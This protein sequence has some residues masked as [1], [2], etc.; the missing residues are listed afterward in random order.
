M[1]SAPHVQPSTSTSQASAA[2]TG[3]FPDRSRTE[4][5]GSVAES[6]S[7]QTSHTAQTQQTAQTKEEVSFQFDRHVQEIRRRRTVQKRAPPPDR[8][9]FTKIEAESGKR[10]LDVRMYWQAYLTYFIESL[11]RDDKVTKIEP[12]QWSK[13]KALLSRLYDTSSPVQSLAFYVE[14]VM[15]WKHPPQT[16][17]WFT[18]YFTLWFYNLWLPAFLSLFVIK[19]LNNRFGFLGNFKE[20]LD[21]PGSITD[22][23]RE[24]E[25]E[26]DKE[27]GRKGKMQSQ[28]REL[29]HS[30]DLA[31]WISQMTKIWGPYG[32]ALLEEN[33]CY[34]ERVKNLFRWERPEQTWRVVALLASCIF[35]SSCF[36]HMVVPAVGLFLGAEFFVLL[37]LQKYYPRFRHVFTP[38]E[39][40]LWGVPNSAELA[41]EMLTRQDEEQR[42]SSEEAAG[43]S[44][45]SPLLEEE[46]TRDS[47]SQVSGLSPASK[48]KYEYQK[49]VR[50]RSSSSGSVLSD[51][52]SNDGAQDKSEYHCLFKGK[53]GKLVITE[54]A[55]QFR[56][57]KI[58]GREV[59]A[60]IPWTKVDSIKK[61]KTMNLGIWSMPGIDVT[62]IDGRVMAFHNVV[63]RDDAFRKLVVTSR[64]KWS[65]VA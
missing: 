44:L 32:Q 26:K 24:N 10:V 64:K 6:T 59:D 15:Y 28:L 53:P 55:L 9:N 20:K 57:A 36:P 4:R 34:L 51:A 58:L 47:D 48:V 38:A 27:N 30:K 46:D 25:R 31:D 5:P 7:G 22:Q 52:Q 60:E 39:W 62:D 16:F 1:D 19:I 56:L 2:H 29:I 54:E 41:V 13:M 18:A 3:A 23:V 17:A 33:L 40:I 43:C 63:H 35:I 8:D 37:P 14:Q 12:L 45:R 21:V 49:R 65:P 61:S 42:R 50:E 11:A